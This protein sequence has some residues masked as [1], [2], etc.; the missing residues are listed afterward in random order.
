[1][2][3]YVL[4]EQT[5]H[6]DGLSS[7]TLPAYGLTRCR[8]TLHPRQ[9]FHVLALVCQLCLLRGREVNGTLRTSPHVVICTASTFV[10]PQGTAKTLH[11]EQNGKM[12]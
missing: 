5:G 3:P 4:V 8:K 2:V 10:V 7:P 11:G 12:R 6:D 1:M 9:R